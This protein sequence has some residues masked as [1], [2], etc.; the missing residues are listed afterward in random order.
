MKTLWERLSKENKA[1]LKG[2]VILY[3]S[4]SA[5]LINA[6]QKEVAWSSLL[7]EHVIWL[8]QETTGKEVSINNVES[9][10]KNK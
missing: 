3:P 4:A 9:L 5:S 6:L 1:K 2:S 8:L 7:F 10:F